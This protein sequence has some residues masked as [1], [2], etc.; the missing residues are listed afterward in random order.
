MGLSK[1]VQN[2]I[3]V[4]F[5]AFLL[6]HSVLLVEATTQSELQERIN[7]NQNQL[8]QISGQMDVLES[9]QEILDEQISDMNAELVNLYTS[10]DVLQDEITAKE[11][12]IIA[13]EGEIEEAQA[14]YDEAKAEEEKQ[15]NA[16]KLRIKFLYES[17]NDSYLQLLLSSE[18]LGAALDRS[19]YIEAIYAY[20][21]KMLTNFQTIKAQV[22][23][24]KVTLE[25]EKT[26]LEADKAVIEEEKK[27]L[28]GQQDYLN[29]V[30][31]QKKAESA[32]YEAEI[33]SAREQAKAFK[34]QIAADNKALE[35]LK[36]EERKRLLAQQGGTTRV[37]SNP[38]SAETVAAAQ[39][40][41]SSSGGSADGKNIA[42]YACQFIGNPYVPGGTSLTNGAD[43]SGFIFRVYADHGYKVPR[44][45]YALREVGTAV[46]LGSAQP[47]DIVCYEGHVAMYIGSGKIVHASTQKTGIKV[48]NVNYRPVLTVRR[49]V[50]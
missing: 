15:Y 13:K 19:E 4:T 30:L 9:Q 44:T 17:G 45:S 10:I 22:A 2:F 39:A 32:N 47:G 38:A 5:A 43:C 28:V 1:R 50:G 33:A 6:M 25:E 40:I 24:M 41:V 29:S 23:A 37:A 34:A 21:R 20:D 18:S 46:D 31:A 14:A 48:S 42:S 7:Q 27:E 12:E 8:N 49:I 35:Q 11:Q 3:C 16:M 36:E 26:T